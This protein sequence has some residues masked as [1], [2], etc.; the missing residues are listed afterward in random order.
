MSFISV[1]Q[2]K[3]FN[4]MQSWHHHFTSTEALLLFTVNVSLPINK[5]ASYLGKRQAHSMSK[6]FFNY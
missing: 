1:T 6:G 4:A 5:N 3:T 2:K